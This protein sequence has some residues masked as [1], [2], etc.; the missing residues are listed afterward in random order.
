MDDFVRILKVVPTHLIKKLITTK[1]CYFHICTLI[2][3]FYSSFLKF[4]QFSEVLTDTI[5]RYNEKT[6]VN[7]AYHKE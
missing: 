3:N 5:F 6:E 1:L 4:L 2:N 7:I